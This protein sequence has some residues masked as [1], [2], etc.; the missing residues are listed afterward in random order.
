MIILENII[1]LLRTSENLLEIKTAAKKL[2]EINSF[3]YHKELYRM[4]NRKRRGFFRSRYTKEH[5]IVALEALAE[6]GTEE[7][8]CFLENFFKDNGKFFDSNYKEKIM[9]RIEKTCYEREKWLL[10]Y[11]ARKLKQFYNQ[12]YG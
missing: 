10:E 4:A 8:R 2:A 6:T 5:M 9:Q 12:R 7:A 11:E 3:E 1:K